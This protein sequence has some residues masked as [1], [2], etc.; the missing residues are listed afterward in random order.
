MLSLPGKVFVIII[1]GALFGFNLYGAIMLKLSFDQNRFLPP[2][3]MSYKYTFTNRKVTSQSWIKLS[4][5]ILSLHFS[6][7]CHTPSI[8]TYFLPSINY[9]IQMLVS[10]LVFTCTGM[11]SSNTFRKIIVSS[12]SNLK[13]ICSYIAVFSSKRGLSEHIYRYAWQGVFKNSL[14]S[15]LRKF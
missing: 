4:T 11:L 8:P 3:S 1:T 9:R 15:S 6:P 2:D 5:H 13:I 14:L 12:W 7:L 10:K